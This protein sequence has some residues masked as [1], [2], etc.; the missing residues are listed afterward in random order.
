MP[1]DYP[2]PPY[3]DCI[4]DDGLWY[5]KY[6]PYTADEMHA[7]LATERARIEREVMPLLQN[8]SRQPLLHEIE[9]ILRAIRGESSPTGSRT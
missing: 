5:A 6:G 9:A 4:D 8:L 7:Y 2:P 1:T 3:Q